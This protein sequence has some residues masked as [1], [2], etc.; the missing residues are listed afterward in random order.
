MGMA[1]WGSVSETTEEVELMEARR[2][3]QFFLWER[4]ERMV[5]WMISPSTIS[6]GAGF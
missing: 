4:I 2:A 5:N 1:L 6:M 3:A